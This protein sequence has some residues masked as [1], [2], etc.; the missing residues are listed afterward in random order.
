MRL[1]VGLGN[2][3]KKYQKT[4]HNI[5]FIILEELA[6]KHGLKFKNTPKLQSYI[7]EGKTDGEKIIMA[8]PLTYMNDSGTALGLI[9]K[10]YKIENEHIILG[11]IQKIT[12]FVNYLLI[13][14][15]SLRLLLQRF[16]LV[17]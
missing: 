14:W 5:G 2:P 13:H 7:A 4:R 6:A 10:F 8:M 9:K 16:G 3:G 15:S 1:I 12:D 17:V 11:M